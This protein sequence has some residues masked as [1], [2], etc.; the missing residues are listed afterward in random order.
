[1]ASDLISLRSR[2]ARN[3]EIDN[4]HTGTVTDASASEKSSAVFSRSYYTAY[5]AGEV[6]SKANPKIKSKN[7]YKNN[8][9]LNI[10]E[11]V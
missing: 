10:L 1:M 3:Q 8:E 11:K 5:N 4:R 6:I 7:K 9:I 2:E